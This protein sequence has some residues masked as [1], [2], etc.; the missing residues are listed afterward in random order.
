MGYVSG[1]LCGLG[2]VD[3]GVRDSGILGLPTNCFNVILKAVK[4][5]FT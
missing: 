5:K 2:G 4:V 3:G 1:V